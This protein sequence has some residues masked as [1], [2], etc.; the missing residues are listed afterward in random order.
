MA[1][2]LPSDEDEGEDEK[3][4]ILPSKRDLVAE[5]GNVDAIA[6]RLSR[7]PSGW[8]RGRA[9]HHSSWK[10]SSQ[11]LQLNR[12]FVPEDMLRSNLVQVKVEKEASCDE[13]DV[14]TNDYDMEHST[15]KES[16]STN[17]RVQYEPTHLAPLREDSVLRELDREDKASDD[18]MMTPESERVQVEGGME[19][20][21]LPY[22]SPTL[23][24][25]E[26]AR[27]N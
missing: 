18:E 3:L 17:N 15:V 25:E 8:R 10:N 27:R 11:P 13:S 20:S 23:G 26:R 5:P 19:S 7:H 24:R 1:D 4:N 14:G 21:L 12:V 2:D 22:K 16:V 9:I 6:L